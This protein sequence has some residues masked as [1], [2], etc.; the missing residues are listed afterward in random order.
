MN[1][2]PRS[3][4]RFESRD[5]TALA[6]LL[7]GWFALPLLLGTGAPIPLNDD[8]AY[9]QTVRTLLETGEFRRPSWTWVPAITHTAWG[10]LFTQVFGFTFQALRW[11]SLVAGAFGLAGAFTL[12]RRTG[13]ATA[14]AALLAATFAFNPVHV[15][16]AFTF[17]TDVPFIAL[18]LWS[19][20]FL[21]DHLR[22]GSW[23]AL[24][25][26]TAL[27]IA[28]TLSRQTALVLP[29]AF[30]VAAVLARP[31][32]W[33]AWLAAAL[34]VGAVG[35]V[36]L[37][38]EEWLFATGGRWSRLYSVRDASKF[39]AAA[40]PAIPFH[41]LKHGV[42]TLVA[43]GWFLLPL[44]LRA[45]AP[46]RLRLAASALGIALATFLML[47]LDLALPPTYN[48]VR[49]LGLGPL[50]IGGHEHL[51]HA[52]RWLWW[53]LTALGAAAG[54]QAIAFFLARTLP[55]LRET[56]RRADLLLLLAF[57]AGFLLPHLARPPFFDRYVFT[58]VAPLGVALL[59]AASKREP[60]APRWRRVA[61]LAA[62]ALF[63]L[64][65]FVGT[66]DYLV[67][68]EAK[69][70]LLQELRAQGYGER[71]V[72][73]GI[74]Y[75]GWFDDFDPYERAPKDDFVWD[76]EFVASYAPSQPGYAQHAQQAYMRWL[77][78]GEERVYVLRRIERQSQ[79]A[80]QAL[81]R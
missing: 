63:V 74:E 15:H 49:D 5:W 48:I 28:A 45:A 41:L 14:G 12:A 20:V 35:F 18:C 47:R 25:A 81:P 72:V 42:A 54:A 80:E 24:I 21:G 7:A 61:S 43:L 19:L 75:N 79:P 60:D 65:S 51:P 52:P 77:P 2:E 11:S 26:G 16:L 36:Y 33:R 9:A 4:T 22:S 62:L 29:A 37:R 56:L 34:C 27:A 46:L 38:A 32:A 76:D 8:W 44:T 1:S 13:V 10:A 71:V 23:I 68:S 69:W 53:A 55:R 6:L 73:G 31:L 67:R 57:S 58:L 66:R 50:T 39:I 40:Q 59:A 3:S 78:F 70:A 64:F 17:M 30:A